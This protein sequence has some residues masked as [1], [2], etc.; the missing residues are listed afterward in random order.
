MV[1]LQKPLKLSLTHTR[2]ETTRGPRRFYTI[3]LCT[4]LHFINKTTILMLWARRIPP[5]TSCFCVALLLYLVCYCRPSSA[6]DSLPFHPVCVSK[7][8][9]W[10]GQQAP[11]NLSGSPTSAWREGAATQYNNPN[12]GGLGVGGYQTP[13]EGQRLPLRLNSYIFE[14]QVSYKNIS[15]TF[16]CL[17]QY[18]GRDFSDIIHTIF[19][20]T[21]IRKQSDFGFSA[22]A[23]NRPSPPWLAIPLLP[24]RHRTQLCL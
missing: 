18:N 22:T 2:A 6:A 21:S 11:R 17:Q 19:T 16:F 23:N 3:T 12:R 5:P 20:F 4:L 1:L 7:T 10:G 13:T 9:S 15:V 24:W 14:I 8:T